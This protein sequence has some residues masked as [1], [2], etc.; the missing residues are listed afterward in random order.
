MS[1]TAKVYPKFYIGFSC[2]VSLICFNLEQ[3]FNLPCLSWLGIYKV[4]SQ[5]FCWMSL[6]LGS[7]DICSWLNSP[8]ALLSGTSCKRC[9]WRHAQLICPISGNVNFDHLVQV[10]F[11]RLLHCKVSIFLFVIYRYLWGRNS[12]RLWKYPVIPQNFYPLVAS[13]C[14]IKW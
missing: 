6:S 1:F 2:F 7:F 3:F 12:W 4:L 8:H 5:L 11:V 14:W 9:S 10:G 13:I